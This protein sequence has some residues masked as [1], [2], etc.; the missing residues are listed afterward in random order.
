M[1]TSVLGSDDR[2]ARCRVGSPARDCGLLDL[3]NG[4][5]AHV[6]GLS[7][8]RTEFDN[9][10]AIFMG[11]VLAAALMVTPGAADAGCI[12]GAVAGGV[13]GHFAHHTVIGAVG[14][15]IAGHYAAKKLRER[16]QPAQVPGPASGQAPAR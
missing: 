6:S 5:K 2:E 14:G 8:R 11:A 13:A 10:K 4:T 16:R 15:C 7:E 9:M 12:K 3:A 1:V